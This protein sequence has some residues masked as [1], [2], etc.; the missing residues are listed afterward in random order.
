MVYFDAR[1]H[2][3]HGS[4]PP[5]APDQTPYE[6]LR[7]VEA[8]MHRLARGERVD[9]L[10]Q[11]ALEQLSSGGKR[12]R[13]QLALGACTALGVESTDAITWAAAVE[14]L[15]NA[16]LI[17]DD[18][19][20]G[21]TTR[22][23]VP[24]LWVHHGAAQAINAGDFMLMLPFVALGRIE[25]RSGHLL[26]ELLARSATNIVRGQVEELGLLGAGRVDI[27]SYRSAARGKTGE[28]IALPVTGAM[29]LAGR[30][31]AQARAVGDVFL[32]LGVLFQIQDDIVDLFGDKGRELRGSDV[33]EGKVSALVVALCEAEPEARARVLELLRRSRAECTAEDVTRLANT[34]VSSGAL[35]R[36]LGWLVALE[37]RVVSSPVLAREPALVPV[38]ER[39]ARLALAPVQHLL[40]REARRA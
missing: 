34:F 36:A 21:D 5:S 15:H 13:A 22:R 39:L 35:D 28:L 27:D 33:Y 32:D 16:T 7:L 6:P 24:T 18:V 20:D 10:G 3:P 1:A 9:R 31:E 40:S 12:F 19:Q 30:S 23:G 8:L 37:Q 4:Q 25:A 14:L 2:S 26:P 17:H 38:A 29:L 11:M